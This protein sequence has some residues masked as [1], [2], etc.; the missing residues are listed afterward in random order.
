M[1]VVGVAV[2]VV[3]LVG[4]MIIKALRVVLSMPQTVITN[5]I[6]KIL[7]IENDYARHNGV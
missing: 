7:S 5:I 3:V 2:N 6:M 1:V 4:Y